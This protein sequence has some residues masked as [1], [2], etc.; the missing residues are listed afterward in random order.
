MSFNTNRRTQKTEEALQSA[1]SIAERN[2][3]ANLEPEHL[4][5]ALLDQGDGVVPQVL[6]K[7]NIAVGALAQQVRE[8]LNKLPRATG[9]NVQLATSPRFQTVLRQ[10]YDEMPQFGDEYLSTEHLLLSILSRS[11][12]Q[13]Q[14][15]LEQAGLT[16]SNL[17]DALRAVRGSQRVTS[18]NPE[19]TYAALDQYGRNLTD[20]ARK[21]KLDPVIGRDEEI[22]RVIQILSRRTKNNPVLIGEPGALFV[23]MCQRR[24]K[25]KRCLH[26]IWAR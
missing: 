19:S 1:Q 11:G 10:A 12:G 18:A 26:S 23:R 7:L 9:S 21:G 13:A 17:L 4:L 3:N 24:S 16:R 20:L 8:A 6:T 5:L 2:G 25:T 15:L 14:R 22:R